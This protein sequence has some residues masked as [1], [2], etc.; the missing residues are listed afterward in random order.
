VTTINGLDLET[1]GLKQEDGERIVEICMISYDLESATEIAR[2]EKRINPKKRIEAKAELIHGI[3]LSEL[4][5][6]PV[7]SDVVGEI[8]EVI[9]SSDILIAHNMDFDGPFLAGEMIRGGHDV[10]DVK[11][12]CTMESGRWATATGK[13]PSLRELCFA[14]DVKYNVAEAHAAT[15]D[16]RKM[17]DCFFYARNRGFY[18]DFNELVGE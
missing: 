18:Q 1:T 17:M 2:Y 16:T 6:E 8:G 15:Y 14:C 5:T 11:S 9:E 7:W 10:P 13:K 12:F 3:S 4:M